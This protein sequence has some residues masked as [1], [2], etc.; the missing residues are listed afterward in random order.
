[1][2]LS[3]TG[4]VSLS[5]L[6]DQLESYVVTLKYSPKCV[7]RLNF[8]APTIT[9]QNFKL[10]IL[11]PPS[12]GVHSIL[13]AHALQ[14]QSR[15]H[16]YSDFV[17]AATNPSR[18]S[19]VYISRILDP[20]LNLSIEHFLLQKT[21][22][23]STIL[24]LYTNR[25][26]IVIGRNQNP[27]VEVNLGIL[28]AGTKHVSLV[29]RRSGG[30][31]VFHDEGNV[32]YS[33]ICPTA[34]FNRNKHA[35]MVVRALHTLGVEHAKVN[36]RHD[37]ILENKFGER[38]GLKPFKVSGSAYKLTRLRSLHHGTCLLSSPNINSVSQYLRSP[39]KAFIKARGVDSVS[40]PISN[41]DVPNN[42]FEEA[43]VS[44]F[45][46]L[47]GV[48]EPML[49]EEDVKNVHEIAKGLE[50][51][52]SLE[53]IYLQTPQFT[54]S[55]K[56]TEDDPKRR[57][58]L[59]NCL[60]PDLNMSFTARNGSIT[61]ASLQYHGTRR[62]ADRQ[63][64]NHRL[65][66]IKDWSQFFRDQNLSASDQAI[67]NWLN[68]LFGQEAAASTSASSTAS[69]AATATM[70]ATSGATSLVRG[71]EGMPSSTVFVAV[72][73]M[74][75]LKDL[76]RRFH[77]HG[78]VDNGVPC[79]NSNLNSLVSKSMKR[80]CSPHH[81]L[82][83]SSC[84]SPLLPAT[85]VLSLTRRFTMASPPPPSQEKEQDYTLIRP[86]FIDIG[87]NLTDSVYSGLYHGTQRHPSD[88]SSVIRR[89]KEAGSQKL[90]VTGSDLADSQFLPSPT[91]YLSSLQSLLTSALASQ[92]CVAFGEIGL[93]YDRL[94]LCPKETQLQY[95]AAQLDIV[96]SLPSPPPLFLHSRAAHEDF[97]RVLSDNGRLERLKKRGVVHSFTGSREEMWM[98]LE[99]GWSIG[100]NGC[101][102]KTEGNLEVVRDVPLDRLMLETDGPWCEVR[103]SHAGAK[104]LVGG[105]QNWE[106]KWKSVKK[107]KWVEGAMIKG[108]NEPCMIGKVAVIVAA[109]KGISVE[110]VTERVWKNTVRMFG[111]GEVA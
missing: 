88:L 77:I 12:R 91:S 32:N 20:Y 41:V 64:V 95:F 102:L 62:H 24:F 58:A 37:I 31:T 14:P 101:S 21:P 66:E 60:P 44:E 96:A 22:P 109:V 72:V 75:M 50:E 4:Q 70:S 87:I 55:T 38:E 98:L 26:C 90:I 17:Q 92:A 52:Q 3:I 45:G 51:L 94:S 47:H 35:E 36:E 34:D 5:S 89:A 71:D 105:G 13:R 29:R 39:A 57:P 76:E 42:F 67:S 68:M 97:L 111:L 103:A 18:Q 78:L 104:F 82:S 19:Q 108:R 53:W 74:I 48:E 28:N 25:P 63:F 100:V 86:R 99:G 15:I 8:Y 61:E 54:F 6:R 80:F 79:F 1:M 10:E 40:S 93:D 33:V 49:L 83:Q 84:L 73:G 43:V 16:K 27:W 9:P 23:D 85:R 65:H 7:C 110:E 46:D 30:G 81:L 56:E 107:E 2:R 106:E 69:A 11:M 59:P